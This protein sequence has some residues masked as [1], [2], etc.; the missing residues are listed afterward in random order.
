MSAIMHVTDEMLL[1]MCIADDVA[2]RIIAQWKPEYGELLDF[3]GGEKDVF[4]ND[5]L[6]VCSGKAANLAR[7]FG[8]SKAESIAVIDTC[9]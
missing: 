1:K 5:L 6:A 7:I 9:K 4:V 2:N 3:G 8:L